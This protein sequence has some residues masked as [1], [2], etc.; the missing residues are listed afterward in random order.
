MTNTQTVIGGAIQVGDLLYP[1]LPHDL[2][3]TDGALKR[4]THVLITHPDPKTGRLWS[5]LRLESLDGTHMRD[6]LVSHQKSFTV[7]RH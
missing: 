5:Q 3:H 7:E 2:D 4:V 1:S 6:R